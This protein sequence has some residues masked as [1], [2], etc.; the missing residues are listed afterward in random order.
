ML[1]IRFALFEQNDTLIVL[2]QNKKLCTLFDNQNDPFQ[3]HNIY[4][5]KKSTE[6]KSNLNQRLC[7]V[8]SQSGEKRPD[9]IH[10]YHK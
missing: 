7:C 2:V 4:K 8:V 10:R 6:I 1:I 9:Y 5:D 3:L